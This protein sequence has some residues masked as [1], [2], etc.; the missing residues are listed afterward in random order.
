MRA[1]SGPY[2]SGVWGTWGG[3]GPTLESSNVRASVRLVFTSFP[4]SG[5]LGCD[6]GALR[7]PS[8]TYTF[9]HLPPPRPAALE[10]I[11]ASLCL[12][13]VLGALRS[14]SLITELQE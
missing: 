3:Q 13:L 12:A 2:T 6:L 9:S 5:G 11:L 4:D 10:H 14:S 8:V 7:L 1:L